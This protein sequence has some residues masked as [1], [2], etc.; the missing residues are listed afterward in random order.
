MSFRPNGSLCIDDQLHGAMTIDLESRS[1]AKGVMIQT[2]RPAGRAT[3][4][5]AGE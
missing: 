5:T 2:Y 1:T 4:G 3:F